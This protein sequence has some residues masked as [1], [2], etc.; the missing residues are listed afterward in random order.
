VTPTSSP[1]KGRGP[2]PRFRRPSTHQRQARPG[3]GV[4]TLNVT[5]LF[6]FA[7]D[8]PRIVRAELEERFLGA[9]QPGQS[10]EIVL[11]AKPSH[12]RAGKVLRIGKVVG[13]RIPSDDPTERQDSRVVECVLAL[14]DT[15][16]LI[17]QRVIVRFLPRL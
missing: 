11:E 4:S 2:R 12:R 5:P 17:G 6:L 8:A 13:Q 3:N 16:L 15:D 1:A 7:P 9:V 14:D 10:A